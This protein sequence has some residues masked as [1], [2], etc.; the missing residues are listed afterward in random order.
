MSSLSINRGNSKSPTKGKLDDP[1]DFII[2]VDYTLTE[3]EKQLWLLIHWKDVYYGFMRTVDPMTCAS[4]DCSDTVPFTT[5]LSIKEFIERHEAEAK[6]NVKYV[7]SWAVAFGEVIDNVLY[8][9]KIHDELQTSLE[10]T[11]MELPKKL[12]IGCGIAT[13]AL[14][15]AGS[16]IGQKRGY[17]ATPLKL[18][19]VIPAG[20][21]MWKG[22]EYAYHLVKSKI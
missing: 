2:N 1:F 14:Y 21:G 13:V 5:E 6:P 11:G 19:A 7:F 12:L 18:A 15:A 17:I 9:D 22:G 4:Y 3:A 8:Y 20:I 10:V 16:V